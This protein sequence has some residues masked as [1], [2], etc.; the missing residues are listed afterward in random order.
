[1]GRV[2][3]TAIGSG[4]EDMKIETVLYVYLSAGFSLPI[5]FKCIAFSL[6]IVIS[7]LNL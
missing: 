4:D 7:L 6:L 5:P 1:M 3:I 2:V